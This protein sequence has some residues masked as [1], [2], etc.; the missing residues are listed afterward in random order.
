MLK[1]LFSLVV[2]FLPAAGG[3]FF[4]PGE[5]YYSLQKP[6]LNPPG[7]VFGPVWTLLYFLMA[8]VLFLLWN[9]SAT[10]DNKKAKVFF[11]CQLVLNAAWTPAFFGANN[12]VAGLIILVLLITFVV[13]TIY[14]I[15]KISKGRVFLLIP[16]F[17]WLCFAF[18]LNFEIMRLN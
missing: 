4:K 7:W 8:V 9:D 14:Y 2:C 10:P 6:A 18:Y 17:I 5:W 15:S 12:I 1:F 3:I 13:L 11:Y 16:Y